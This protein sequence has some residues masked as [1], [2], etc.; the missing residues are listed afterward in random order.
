MSRRARL[1]V[2]VAGLIF[3]IVL[4]LQAGVHDLLANL[5]HMGWTFGL[6]V[7]VWALVYASNTVAWR[8]L[9][10]ATAARSGRDGSH[11]QIP[12]LRAYVISIASF[13]VNYATPFVALGG[14]PLRVAA[15]TE[16][17][18]ADRAA[19]SVVSFRVTHTLGQMIFWLIAVPVAWVLMPNTV[20]TRII[21]VVAALTFATISVAI[22]LLFR[23]GFVVRALNTVQHIPLLR[24]LSPRIERFR[25]TLAHIDSQ[26]GALTDGERPRLIMAVLAEVV[27]RSIAML[28]FYIIAHAEGL[29]I[30]YATAF[31]IGAFSQL[32]I[33]LLIFIPFELGSREGGLYLIY[34]LLG[35]PSALGVYAGVIS[36]LR[37]LVWIGIGLTLVWA[38]RKTTETGNPKPAARTA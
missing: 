35:L 25:P 16:W 13:A 3:F 37:E 21:L 5:V 7:G 34:R 20:P 26:L 33:N 22:V 38:L 31:V 18:G 27:G 24:R 6:V 14:E 30:N 15:A 29:Q 9:I 23:H 17:I 1:L 32:T 2:F 28:E 11:D 8:L 36:R 19:A 10:R 12:F 4:I